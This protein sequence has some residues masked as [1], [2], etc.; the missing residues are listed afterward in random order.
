[1]KVVKPNQILLLL[2]CG[3]S[4]LTV[5]IGNPAGDRGDDEFWF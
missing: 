4:L 5:T 2:L 1:M 3:S